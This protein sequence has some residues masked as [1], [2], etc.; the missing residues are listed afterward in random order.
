MPDIKQALALK[1]LYELTQVSPSEGMVVGGWI[2]RHIAARIST[3]TLYEAAYGGTQGRGSLGMSFASM[4]GLAKDAMLL[5]SFSKCSYK[6]L[7]IVHF[8]SRYILPFVIGNSPAGLLLMAAMNHGLIAEIES[9]THILP[10][11][12]NPISDAA[13]LF[14]LRKPGIPPHGGFSFSTQPLTLGELNKSRVPQ[15]FNPKAVDDYILKLEKE[16]GTLGDCMATF[17]APVIQKSSFELL[18]AIQILTKFIIHIN[19]PEVSSSLK[20]TNSDEILDLEEF[21]DSIYC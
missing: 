2:P 20:Y 14:S 17:D 12:E 4:T 9:G 21:F 1:L 13:G 7:E 11:G 8:I 6:P 16:S 5:H 15:L 10:Y 19:S 3:D 18:F